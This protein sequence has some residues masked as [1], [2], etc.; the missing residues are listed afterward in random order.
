MISTPK[1]PPRQRFSFSL[2]DDRFRALL[3]QILVIGAVVAIPARVDH[4]VLILGHSTR[5]SPITLDAASAANA[6]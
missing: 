5:T 3:W 6:W 4:G 1:R 2:Q